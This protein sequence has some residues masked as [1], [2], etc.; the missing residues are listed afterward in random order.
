MT[1]HSHQ[2][3]SCESQLKSSLFCNACERLQQLDEE[4]DYFSIFNQPQSYAID[5]AAIEN[6]FDEMIVNLHPDFFAQ[7]DERDQSLSLHHTSLLHQAKGCLFNPFERGKYLLNLLLPGQDLI[8]GNPPQSFLMEMFELQ[9]DLD[10]L[11]RGQ[12]DPDALAT[13]I[14]GL[15]QNCDQALQS[16]FS[17][18]AP[19]NR[20]GIQQLKDELSKLKFLLNLQT[21][22]EE[23]R[24]KR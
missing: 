10:Q 3:D 4:E 9:E 24:R 8:L 6:N 2:C 17:G 13:K 18:F 11:D 15:V 5:R 20:S 12:G 14:E 7:A 21:R 23:I 1:D 19:E 22:M 16:G